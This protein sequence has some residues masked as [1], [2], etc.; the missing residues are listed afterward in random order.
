MVARGVTGPQC[1]CAENTVTREGRSIKLNHYTL[2]SST[3]SLVTVR[4]FI[5]VSLEPFE[6]AIPLIDDIVAATHE[7]CKNAI[8]H[9]PETDSPVE[10]TCDVRDDSVVVE[11]SDEGRGFDPV[12]IPPSPPDPAAPAGRGIYIIY[13]LMD[14]VEAE[15]GEYGTRVT[16]Q[17]KYE[18]A[19]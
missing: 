5:R 2:D 13:S 1:R 3:A 9:N 11:V 19:A 17:K 4:E 12:I 15:T 10:I 8:V 18:S 7:A 6:L 16:M 14:A